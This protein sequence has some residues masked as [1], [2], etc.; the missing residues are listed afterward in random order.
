MVPLRE[1][2]GLITP[3]IENV[4]YT[5]MSTRR[6]RQQLGQYFLGHNYDYEPILVQSMVP[7]RELCGLIASG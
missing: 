3:G 7:L 5:V 6:A 1:L 4:L 2:C